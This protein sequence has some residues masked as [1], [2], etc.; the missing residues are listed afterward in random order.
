[1][2]HDGFLSKSPSS[3]ETAITKEQFDIEKLQFDVIGV[4]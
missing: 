2:A 1:M 4:V 3:G